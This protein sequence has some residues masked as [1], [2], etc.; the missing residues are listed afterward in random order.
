VRLVVNNCT[1]LSPWGSVSRNAS[2]AVSG[3]RRLIVS[4]LTP[5]SRHICVNDQS[6][7]PAESPRSRFSRSTPSPSWGASVCG[8]GQTS[9]EY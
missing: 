1:G 4:L 7:S 6:V 5:A 8:N 9:A 2:I 3:C